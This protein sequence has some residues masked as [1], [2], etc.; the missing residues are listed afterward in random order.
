MLG[1]AQCPDCAGNRRIHVRSSAGDHSCS[2]GRSVEFV[3]GIKNE[4]GMHG[5]YMRRWRLSAMQEMQEMRDFLKL[6]RF[7]YVENVIAT[8]MQVITGSSHRAKRSVSGND[9]RQG[10][11][12]LCGLVWRGV[13][14][15]I[16]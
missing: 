2:K 5:P 16:L 7:R 4:R 13:A 14:H 10:N 1:T 6:A 15:G 9:A 11:R 12:S 3:L 8:I